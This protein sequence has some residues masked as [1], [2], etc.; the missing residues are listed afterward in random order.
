MPSHGFLSSS[1]MFCTLNVRR[2]LPIVWCNLSSIA[3]AWGFLEVI[4]FT[5]IMKLLD[6]ISLNSARNLLSLLS[7]AGVSPGLI[8]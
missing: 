8:K 5:D 1:T 6:I 7:Y 3:L 4:N 2:M